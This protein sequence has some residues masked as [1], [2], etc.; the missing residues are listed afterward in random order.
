M[1][2]GYGGGGGELISQANTLDSQH[3]DINKS[4]TELYII[5]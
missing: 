3:L 2:V 1:H 5:V 4:V